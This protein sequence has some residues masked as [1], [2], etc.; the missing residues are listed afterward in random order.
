LGDRETYG[1]FSVL[2][3]LGWGH[4]GSFAMTKYLQ[5]KNTNKGIIDA[6]KILAYNDEGTN[7][8]ANTIP[9]AQSALTQAIKIQKGLSYISSL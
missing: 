9:K 8:N 3:L 6:K 1:V 4:I 7:T 2:P 5:D